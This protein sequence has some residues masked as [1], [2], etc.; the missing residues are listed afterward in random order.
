MGGLGG[1]APLPLRLGGSAEQGVTAAQHARLCADL[2]ALS[3][4]QPFAVLVY[5]LDPGGVYTEVD[6]YFVGHLK[7]NKLFS[8]RFD[9]YV[10]ISN[11]FDAD[12][13]QRIGYPREG[14]A[15]LAG[16][17]ARF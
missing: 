6:S 9:G 10:S 14:R 8:S 12:Y 15:F 5:D 2:V 1:F 11:L 4:V 3:R 13:V 16:A 17:E 7:L